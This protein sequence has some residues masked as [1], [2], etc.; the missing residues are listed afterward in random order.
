MLETKKQALEN[1]NLGS[2]KN[3]DDEFSEIE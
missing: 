3:D 2:R 1:L